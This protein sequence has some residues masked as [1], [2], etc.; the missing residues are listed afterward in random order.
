MKRSEQRPN[1]ACGSSMLLG[2]RPTHAAAHHFSP[3]ALS[4]GLKAALH[5]IRSSFELEPITFLSHRFKPRRGGLP[6]FGD[7]AL[8]ILRMQPV[9]L[10]VGFRT[11]R[12]TLLRLRRRPRR[13]PRAPNAEASVG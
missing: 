5:K 8:W 9:R 4:D 3:K 10:R 12:A 2:A 13:R 11:G 6:R 7:F 1:G